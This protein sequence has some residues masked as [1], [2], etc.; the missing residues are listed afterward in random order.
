MC[1]QQKKAMGSIVGQ[2]SGDSVPFV[3]FGCFFPVGDNY[4]L[5]A[6]QETTSKLVVF[7][8]GPLVRVGKW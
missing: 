3:P 5:G 8:G 1:P 7:V 6:S 4:H 2:L